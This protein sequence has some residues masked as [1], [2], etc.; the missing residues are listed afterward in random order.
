MTLS[1]PLCA[2]VRG[3]PRNSQRRQ[4]FPGGNHALVGR[5]TVFRTLK[6]EPTSCPPA[7]ASIHGRVVNNENPP[8]LRESCECGH[9]GNVS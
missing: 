2:G 1:R 7:A 6:I 9:L 5:T 3:E 8:L 4:R